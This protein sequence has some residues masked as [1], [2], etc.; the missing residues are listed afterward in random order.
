MP[1]GIGSD[2]SDFDNLAAIIMATGAADVMRTLQ[3]PAIGALGIA[4]RLERIMGPALITPRPGYL[5][6]RYGHRLKSLE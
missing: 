5:F 1:V 6:L 2:C 3:F 4:H